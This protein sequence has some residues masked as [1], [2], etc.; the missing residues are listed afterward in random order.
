[1]RDSLLFISIVLFTSIEA[2]D[3]EITKPKLLGPNPNFPRNQII[4]STSLSHS[5]GSSR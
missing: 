3:Y 5:C 4:D 1:M 2:F